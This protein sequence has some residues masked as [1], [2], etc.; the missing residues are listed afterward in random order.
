MCNGVHRAYTYIVTP[1]SL[2]YSSALQPAVWYGG[3]P[4]GIDPC[5][6]VPPSISDWPAHHTRDGLQ[7]QKLVF[8]DPKKEVV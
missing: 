7:R 5:S 4:L 3:H 6:G 1:P 8:G 2:F